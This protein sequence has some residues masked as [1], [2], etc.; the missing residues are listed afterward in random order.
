MLTSSFHHLEIAGISAAVPSRQLPVTAYMEVFGEDTVTKFSKMTGIKGV[1]RSIPEQTASDLGYEAALHLLGKTGF[2]GHDIGILVFVTQKPDYRSPSTAFVLQKRLGLQKDCSVF[3]MNMGCSGYVYGLQLVFS[4]LKNS[5]TTS[6]L[7][8]T[9]DTSIRTMSPYDRS[10]IMLFGDCGTATLIKKTSQENPAHVSLRT[11]GNGYK[12]IITLAG[13]Y[14]NMD[15]PT[16]RVAWSDGN[17]RSLYDT[18]LNGVDVFNFTISEVPRL[19]K[20]FMEYLGTT[21]EDYDIFALHQANTYILKQLS[22]KLKMPMEKIH[23]A[24]DR[25]GNASS[26]SIPLV[27]VDAYGRQE[28]KRI[29]AFM[30]GFGVGLSWGCVDMHISAD[31]VYPV[32]HS[33]EFYKEGAL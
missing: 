24:M 7:L 18:Y 30:S 28:G 26:N 21:P 25:Y 15:A 23:I 2:H 11:D 27:L 17:M 10:A 31:D 22:R 19:M 8:I 5:D 29:R 12:A 6:A 3:D 4:M 14:R 33:D 1:F 32:I 9:G 20:E 13:A 16:E